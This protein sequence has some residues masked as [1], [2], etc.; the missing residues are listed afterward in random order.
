MTD[1]MEKKPNTCKNCKYFDSDDK[2]FSGLCKKRCPVI[3]PGY[4]L[5]G[6]FP[7]V[8]SVDSCGEW[9]PLPDSVL[10]KGCITSVELGQFLCR[11]RVL[12]EYRALEY[13]HRLKHNYLPVWER[14]GKSYW[15]ISAFSWPDLEKWDA[16]NSRWYE[17][18]E[19]MDRTTTEGE[20]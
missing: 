1:K 9:A 5:Y 10:P 4:D 11:E 14:L 15:I 18:L 8:H 3:V 12:G 20:S 7:V 17:Y 2:R 16:I 6:K 13:A 19:D